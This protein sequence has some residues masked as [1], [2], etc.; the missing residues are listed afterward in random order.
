MHP[1]T[2]PVI[3]AA[4]AASALARDPA[5]AKRKE[6]AMLAAVRD[7]LAEGVSLDDSDT[8]RARMLAASK[9]V[10]HGA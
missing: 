2:E 10:T 8:I 7:A 9:S 4:V 5:L 6:A 1:K 3:V